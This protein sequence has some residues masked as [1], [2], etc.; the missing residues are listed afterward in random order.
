MPKIMIVNDCMGCGHMDDRTGRCFHPEFKGPGRKVK[1]GTLNKIQEWC[2]LEDL[3][4]EETEVETRKSRRKI[5]KDIN[6]LI[7]GAGLVN[8]LLPPSIKMNYRIDCRR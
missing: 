7:R 5:A 4:K 3:P 2:P 6:T 8:D 1:P